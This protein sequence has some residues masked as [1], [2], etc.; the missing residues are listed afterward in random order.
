LNPWTQSIISH[1]TGTITTSPQWH[2]KLGESLLYIP[3][4]MAVYDKAYSHITC[5]LTAHHH[6]HRLLPSTTSATAPPPSTYHTHTQDSKSHGM[7]C[8]DLRQLM[9]QLRCGVTGNKGSSPYA[10]VSE[11]I[12]GAKTH[13]YSIEGAG[14]RCVLRRDYSC[15]LTEFCFEAE[16]VSSSPCCTCPRDRRCRHCP[17]HGPNDDG[18]RLGPAVS[19]SFVFF[20]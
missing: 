7:A 16:H 13:K 12:F 5:H 11:I 3:F 17:L 9:D 20:N 2:Y 1:T 18:H 19:F 8:F 10:E 14:W 15:T 4:L 6:H